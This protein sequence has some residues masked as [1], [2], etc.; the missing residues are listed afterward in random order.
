MENSRRPWSDSLRALRK[1]EL[2]K[3]REAGRVRRGVVVRNCEETRVE[4]R[5]RDLVRENMIFGLV[6]FYFGGSYEN[7]WGVNWCPGMYVE[8]YRKNRK[9]QVCRVKMSSNLKRSLLFEGAEPIAS[10][11]YIRHLAYVAGISDGP[12][13]GL[14]KRQILHAW[15]WLS[16]P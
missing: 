10:S 9:M 4:R 1:L 6:S 15:H 7:R 16:T 12:S 13:C 14:F 8:E 2:W 3:G 5:V 11:I